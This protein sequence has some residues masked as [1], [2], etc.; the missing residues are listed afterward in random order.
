MLFISND[1]VLASREIEI[2][3]IKA[4]GPGGQNVNK[5]AT[6]IHLRFD[7]PTSSLPEIVKERLLMLNDQ[8]LT[9]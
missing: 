2:S 4:Q 1:I 5:V 3:A 6:A 7:I 9:K 8:R